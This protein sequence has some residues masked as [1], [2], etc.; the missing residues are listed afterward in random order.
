MRFVVTVQEFRD[1]EGNLVAESRSTVI[2]TGRAPQ[3]EG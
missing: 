2:E 1:E 3:K